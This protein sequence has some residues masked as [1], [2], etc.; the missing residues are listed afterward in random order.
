MAEGDTQESGGG[1][2]TEMPGLVTG[3][4]LRVPDRVVARS[5]GDGRRLS[6][7][8]SGA[9]PQGRPEAACARAGRRTCA[10]ASD[11]CAS[12][13]SL[14]RST[15]RRSSRSTTRARS[16]ASS[17]SRCVSSR[18]RSEAPPRGGRAARA[19]AR[20]GVARTGRRRARRRARARTRAPGRQAVERPRRRARPLL[21]GRLRLSRRVAESAVGPGAAG[22]L[23]TVDYVAPEQIRGDEL[24]GRADLYS[25]GCLLYE[26]LAGRPPF[27][28]AS[29]TAVVFAHLEEEPPGL[30]GFEHVMKKA[31]AKEPNDRYQSGRELVAAAREGLRPETR[32]GRGWLVAA[33]VVVAAAGAGIGGYLASR[34]GRSQA[35]P[36][37]NVEQISLSPN[38]LNLIDA[39]TH[40]VGNVGLGRGER[41]RR[42]CGHRVRRRLRVAALR[43]RRAGRR[44]RLPRDPEGHAG[45]EAAVASG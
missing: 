25:L 15:I 28:G 7:T 35:R 1:P 31:L 43:Q 12:H 3:T 9:R 39:R 27:A 32:P 38:A 10:F 21:P 19:V 29:D 34:D 4:E 41:R 2:P 36:A 44:P 8:R 20:A 45:R 37:P 16:P 40:G 6:G 23:G 33:A 24:D 14:R 17:T 42:G 30:P 13:G 22:S 5:R 18:G 26:C 11:S